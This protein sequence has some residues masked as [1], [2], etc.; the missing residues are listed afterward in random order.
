MCD[1]YDK[2]VDGYVYTEKVRGGEE[3]SD[4]LTATMLA[5]RTVQALGSVQ[6][7]IPP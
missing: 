3:R 4:D 1:K 7:V 5:T 2:G 6:D